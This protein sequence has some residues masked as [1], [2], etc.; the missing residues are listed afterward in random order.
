MSGCFGIPRSTSKELLSRHSTLNRGLSVSRASSTPPRSRGRSRGPRLMAPRASSSR[1]T[2]GSVRWPSRAAEY[3]SPPAVS[4]SNR[5]TPERRYSPISGER[6]RRRRSTFRRPDRPAVRPGTSS[7]GSTIRTIPAAATSR[8]TR[9]MRHMLSRCS[10][11]RSHRR[12]RRSRSR[13]S[14]NRRTPG[15]SLNR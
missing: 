8:P 5:S 6:R 12:G 9:T 7:R 2:S 11:R 13:R 4:S 1:R 15:R 3:V 14:C 10:S